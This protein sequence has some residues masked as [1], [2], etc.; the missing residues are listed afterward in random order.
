M[1]REL[2][3]DTPGEDTLRVARL[4]IFIATFGGVILLGLVMVCLKAPPP[5]VQL[6]QHDVIRIELFG[7]PI[8]KGVVCPRINLRVYPPGDS[9]GRD[10]PLDV[11]DGGRSRPGPTGDAAAAYFS[12]FGTIVVPGLS[13]Y[14]NA[15][16]VDLPAGS[17][18]TIVIL[19]KVAGPWKFAVRYI[20][21]GNPD[22]PLA[23]TAVVFTNYGLPGGDTIPLQIPFGEL[24]AQFSVT[25]NSDPD[26][27]KEKTAS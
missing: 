21:G 6:S 10:L 23:V 11:L 7:G 22:N 14:T 19:P 8:P 9:L 15:A 20:N 24:S 25:I 13:Y 12:P 5:S 18:G 1:K 3:A 27:V 2:E 26:S 16:P 4:A 17:L